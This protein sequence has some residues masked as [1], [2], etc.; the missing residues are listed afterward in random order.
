M[1]AS[2]AN[3]ENLMLSKQLLH[4]RHKSAGN[5]R[6]QAPTVASMG[7]IQEATKRTVF[8]DKSNTARTNIPYNESKMSSAKFPNAKFQVY[9]AK[10]TSGSGYA[11]QK[12]AFKR[13]AQRPPSSKGG[14]L[15]PSVT[16]SDYDISLITCDVEPQAPQASVK[17]A[18]SNKASTFVYN[19]NHNI[20]PWTSGSDIIDANQVGS[21]QEKQSFASFSRKPRHHQ[22]QPALKS[23]QQKQQKIDSLLDAEIKNLANWEPLTAEKGTSEDEIAESLYLDA[24]EELS[25]EQFPNLQ[26][27]SSES[28]L[29]VREPEQPYHPSDQD[30]DYQELCVV[31]AADLL[32]HSEHE[33]EDFYDPEQGYTTVHSYLSGVDTRLPDV[34]DLTEVEPEPSMTVT[35][36]D[37]PR[38]SE[39]ALDE[40]EA[41]REHVEKHRLP[42][43][44]ED[45]LWDISMVAEYGDE[46]FEYMREME[47]S[48]HGY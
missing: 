36:M 19:D 6:G 2:V 13:P 34:A 45:E 42:E 46:I 39:Q 18:S 1:R 20:R 9:K 10:D 25:P 33:D 28:A 12:D 4:Q 22:S 26:P 7:Q 43:E 48:F 21:A 16:S 3:N 27:G 11:P 32:D 31:S 5:L 30:L 44:V 47:V 40:I 38:F 15:L 29:S 17:L 35:V 23:A 41:A 8:A 14:S 37:V 24:V